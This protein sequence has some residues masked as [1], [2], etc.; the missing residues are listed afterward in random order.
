MS[1]C[2]SSFAFSLGEGI[3]WKCEVL[4]QTAL[5]TCSTAGHW[6]ARWCKPCSS[7]LDYMLRGERDLILQWSCQSSFGDVFGG[8]KVCSKVTWNCGFL[9]EFESTQMAFNCPLLFLVFLPA[10]SAFVL[11]A[12]LHHHLQIALAKAVQW[13]ASE[14]WEGTHRPSTEEIQGVTLALTSVADTNG[15]KLPPAHA[16]KRKGILAGHTG[17]NSGVGVGY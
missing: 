6:S 4:S 2:R 7:M 1:V 10:S 16:S 12:R 8:V 17:F 13:K 15:I 14:R 3:W 5:L 11:I 9:V